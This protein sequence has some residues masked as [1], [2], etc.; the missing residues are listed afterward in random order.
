MSDDL[1]MEDEDASR[2]DALERFGFERGA[3]EAFLIEHEGGISERL[4]WF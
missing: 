3:M 2:L 1:L 4:S